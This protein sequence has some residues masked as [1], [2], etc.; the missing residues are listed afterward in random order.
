MTYWAALCWLS[1]NQNKL[2]PNR[3]HYPLITY[4]SFDVTKGQIISEQNCG[5][6]NFPKFWDYLTFNYLILKKMGDF[7]R[8]CSLLKISKLY[9]NLFSETNKKTLYSSLKRASLYSLFNYSLRNIHWIHRG[10]I[11]NTTAVL[12]ID[13]LGCPSCIMK[14]HYFG[15]PLSN[16]IIINKWF[17]KKKS[18]T[19]LCGENHFL[20]KHLINERNWM[21]W[22]L[23]VLKILLSKKNQRWQ[24]FIESFYYV[25]K[26]NLS[27]NLVVM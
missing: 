10:L 17:E 3:C 24:G 25:L 15:P 20:S 2:N 18:L 1:E 22:M 27:L 8:F 6:L 19:K 23:Y 14:L 12:A 11:I 4:L 16:L 26:I 21:K 9:R 5:V 7:F 13:K